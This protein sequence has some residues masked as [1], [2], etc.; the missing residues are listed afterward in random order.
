MKNT[1][2]RLQKWPKRCQNVANFKSINLS[3]LMIIVRHIIL[4]ELVDF[5]SYLEHS[6]PCSIRYTNR[7]FY[8][9]VSQIQIGRS[10]FY[11]VDLFWC[12]DL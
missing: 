3:S 12:G 10:C 8:L 2:L 4:N 11:Q 7:V 9:F 5:T 1:L 6:R